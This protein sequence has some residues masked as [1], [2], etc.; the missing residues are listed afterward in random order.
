[1]PE[2][3]VNA[4]SS[5]SRSSF[6]SDSKRQAMM[7]MNKAQLQDAIRARG[8]EPPREW[9]NVELRDRLTELME[10]NGETTSGTKKTDLRQWIAELNKNS[11]K[12]ELLKT[13]CEER[14]KI[15]LSGSETIPVLQKKVSVASAMD[16][17][18]FGKW[19][20]LTYGQLRREQPA[21]ATWVQETLLE[22]GESCDYRLSRLGNWLMNQPDEE[23][24]EV[25]EKMPPT[26]IEPAYAKPKAKAKSMTMEYAGGKG[27]GAKTVPKGRSPMTRDAPASS[28]SAEDASGS[29]AEAMKLLMDT[30]VAMKE[31][32]KQLREDRH[33]EE[34]RRKKKEEPETD[35]KASTE[36]SF[37]MV[38]D[39]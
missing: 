30:M 7:R 1:M 16:P 9:S 21:Y 26:T 17:V 38:L 36:A 39:P 11:K 32:I 6:L 10:L 29:N 22:G 19:S 13:F 2:A 27:Y 12:K 4:Q 31:E 5:V 35:A 25:P 33:P 24:V 37:T 8:E 3:S 34:P 28:S 15:T 20:T 23:T 18:G 14:L